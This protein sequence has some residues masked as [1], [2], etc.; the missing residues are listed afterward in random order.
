[1]CPTSP[2]DRQ[3]WE[4]AII[5]GLAVKLQIP[6]GDA[7]GIIESESFFLAQSWAR[8]DSP[9]VIVDAIATKGLSDIDVTD[10]VVSSDEKIPTLNPAHNR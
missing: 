1:M 10:T 5:D 2:Q 7:Q 8:N 9:A 4:R 6:N 3:A